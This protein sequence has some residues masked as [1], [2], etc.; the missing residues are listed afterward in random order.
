MEGKIIEWLSPLKRR[1]GRWQNVRRLNLVLRL[2]TLRARGEAHEAGYASIVRRQ[3]E[4]AGNRSHLPAD[5]ELPIEEIKGKPPRQ[6]SWWRSG[7]DRGEASFPR[8]VFESADRA[9][10]RAA[11]DHLA[12]VPSPTSSRWLSASPATSW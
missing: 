4:A 2:I 3:F 10:Q 6:M 12:S 11:D 5:S 7:H 8:L 9:K 1:A